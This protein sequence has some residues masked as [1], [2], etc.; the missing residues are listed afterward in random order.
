MAEH[1][2]FLCHERAV[3]WIYRLQEKEKINLTN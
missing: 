2:L 1:C 3:D